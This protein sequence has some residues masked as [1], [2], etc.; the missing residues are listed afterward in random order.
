MP[1]IINGTGL[2]DLIDFTFV[3]ALG[4]SVSAAE[5]FVFAGAGNDEV[6]SGDGNDTVL[7][8]TGDDRVVA[9]KGDDTVFGE[10]GNDSL[11]GGRGNDQLFGGDGEDYLH[12]GHGNDFLSGGAGNDTILGIKGHNTIEGGTGDDYISTGDHTSTVDGGADDDWINVRMKKGGD[13]TLTGGTG[14]DMFEFIQSAASKVSDVLITDFELGTDSF[15]IE[16]VSDFAYLNVFF[17]F[18]DE[19]FEA[20]YSLTDT[21]AGTVLEMGTGDSITF[22]GVSLDD[23]TAYYLEEFF[24]A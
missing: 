9:G 22:A 10:E 23:F 5:D 8:G 7:A 1:T 3:D 24:L 16:G 11:F 4:N 21:E 2:D 18:E 6:Y 12:G 17:G 15:M 20:D 19:I 14:A 13:H